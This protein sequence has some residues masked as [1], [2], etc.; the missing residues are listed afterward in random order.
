MYEIRRI[1]SDSLEILLNRLWSFER[2]INHWNNKEGR[3][4]EVETSVTYIIA[5]D[6]WEGTLEVWDAEKSKG[7]N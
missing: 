7:N 4:I 2:S 5:E 1:S 3:K 6:V